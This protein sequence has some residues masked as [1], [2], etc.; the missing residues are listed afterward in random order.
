MVQNSN[1]VP[2]WN[3]D[4]SGIDLLQSYNNKEIIIYEKKNLTLKKK[5]RKDNNNKITEENILCIGDSYSNITIWEDIESYYYINNK[6]YICPKG[7]NYLTI[8]EPNNSYEIQK[9]KDKNELLN[10][11][12]ELICNLQ[13]KKGW[14]FVA[15]LNSKQYQKLYGIQYGKSNELES[16]GE[17]LNLLDF[18]LTTEEGSNFE[19]YMLGMQLSESYIKLRKIII[20]L[21]ENSI[22]NVNA[23]NVTKN[24]EKNKSYSYAYFIY[25]DNITYYINF[26]NLS[27]FRC[28]HSEINIHPSNIDNFNN[29]NIKSYSESPFKFLGKS[30]IEKLFF[31]RNTQYAYYKI[32][33]NN[34]TY[35]GVIDV[36]SNK[37]IFNTNENIQEFKPLL[38]IP[39]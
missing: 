6:Y 3:L 28:G 4:N 26:N 32:I 37:T 35:H 15:F 38:I 9:P 14:L 2:L 5:I 7:K 24:F 23:P 11:E 12:W 19:Y 10:D 39:Y 25:P 13:E 18:V 16:R 20:I 1:F 29:Y 31:I 33:N 27:D 30:Q 21:D 17:E 36:K 8:I 22:W 34:I